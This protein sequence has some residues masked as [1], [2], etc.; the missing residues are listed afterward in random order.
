MT[1]MG[2]TKSRAVA[3]SWPSMR[4]TW[5]TSPRLQD[6]PTTRKV[7][8]L[9][10]DGTVTTLEPL[11]RVSVDVAVARG[12]PDDRRSGVWTWSTALVVGAL[13]AGIGYVVGKMPCWKSWQGYVG[14]FIVAPIAVLAGIDAPEVLFHCFGLALGFAIAHRV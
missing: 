13:A 4:S 10:A 7:T 1:T 14:L 8:F 2:A 6:L 12:V 9:H 11:R 5:S 3:T